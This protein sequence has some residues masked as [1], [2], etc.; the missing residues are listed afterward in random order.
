[1][2]LR[3]FSY[4]FKLLSE[5]WSG[6]VTLNTYTATGKVEIAKQRVQAKKQ[7]WKDEVLESFKVKRYPKNVLS[8]L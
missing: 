6:T 7:E 5:D 1:M 4:D 8:P 2:I 3:E